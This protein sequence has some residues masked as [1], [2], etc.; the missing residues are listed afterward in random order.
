MPVSYSRRLNVNCPFCHTA[1]PVQQW[2]IV[3][4]KERPDLRERCMD[5]TIQTVQCPQ[6]HQIVCQ[7]PLLL[8]DAAAKQVIF[9]PQDD[10][11]E[12]EENADADALMER[13]L[14]TILKRAD[15]M[16]EVM[17]A[18]PREALPYVLS[19]SLDPGTISKAAA[20][21]SLA[22]MRDSWKAQGL[23]ASRAGRH[24]AAVGYFR[25]ALQ[26]SPDD[27]ATWFNC[28]LSL[29]E[30]G[31]VD[32]T[33]TCCD[34]VLEVDPT[35]GGAAS[36]R[37][38]ALL[39]AGRGA[40]AMRWLRDPA[41]NHRPFVS[42]LLAALSAAPGPGS[43]NAEAASQ[44]SLRDTAARLSVTGEFVEAVTAWERVLEEDPCDAGAWF[45]KGAALGELGRTVE[46]MEAYYRALTLDPKDVQTLGNL[47]VCLRRA[48][49][50]EEAI[51]YYDR[52]LG[53]KPDD[54]QLLLNK[55]VAVGSLGRLD[56]EIAC[57]TRVI[58]LNP[59]N[60]VAWL[61]K[62]W[63]LFE[64]K[65][66]QEALEAFERALKI[67]PRETKAIEGRNRAQ[68]ELAAGRSRRWW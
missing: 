35:D 7:G 8:H 66:Y 55:G 56:E 53:V 41:R 37:V 30:L 50:A 16:E 64:L 5:G 52:A 27:S 47:A 48:G 28:A 38:M 9:S 3:D 68:T 46:E 45:S 61:N 14:G 32:E 17:F 54:E 60:P 39:R 42:V 57:C 12:D 62:G 40:D 65:R 67:N 1:F 59:F 4:F 33:I 44:T 25:R 29:A 11:T 10:Q 51:T 58:S 6:S 34:K 49:R 2:V 13:F 20:N 36:L 15:Y 22:D 18:S 31:R 24:E 26:E 21:P 63:A 43:P 19:G 23:R